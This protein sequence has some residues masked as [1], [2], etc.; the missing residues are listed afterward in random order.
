ME[1]LKSLLEIG[2][3]NWS[4][5]LFKSFLLIAINAIVLYLIYLLIVKLFIKRTKENKDFILRSLFLWALFIFSVLFN[6]YWF[7]LIKINGVH[8]F[9]WSALNFYKN[10][11]PQILNYI[12]LI[13]IFIYCYSKYNILIKNQNG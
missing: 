8:V 11:S 4:E 9:D 2:V 10:I 12:L 5:F 1:P 3:R 6:V 13:I 7:Y